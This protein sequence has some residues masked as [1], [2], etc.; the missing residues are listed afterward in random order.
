MKTQLEIGK[1]YKLRDKKTLGYLW[2]YN[3][4]ELVD[5][6]KAG[7]FVFSNN[8]GYNPEFFDTVPLT[9]LEEVLL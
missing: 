8:V 4:L 2:G 6:N 1:L 7:W 3:A 9:E 5:V